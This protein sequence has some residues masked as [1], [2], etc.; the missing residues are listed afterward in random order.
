MEFFMAMKPNKIKSFMSCILVGVTLFMVF[1]LIISI[2]IPYTFSFFFSEYSILLFFFCWI[3]FS[4]SFYFQGWKGWLFGLGITLILFA[5]PLS[6]KW[7]SGIS[8]NQIIAGL[9]PYKD[10][11]YYYNGALNIL[12]GNMI[13]SNNLPSSWRPLFP[14][15]FSTLLFLTGR[16]LKWSIALLTYFAGV[17]CYLA[18]RQMRTISG[19]WAA[20]LFMVFLFFYSSPYIGFLGT[21]LSG[22]LVSCLAFSLLSYAAQKFEIK[23]LL[24]GMIILMLAISTR[25]GAFVIFPMLVLWSGWF[26][27]KERRFS[28][29]VAGLSFLVAL[30]SFLLFN[31]L[32]QKSIVEPGEAPLSNFAYV[33]YGQALGGTGWQRGVQDFGYNSQLVFSTALELIQKHPLSFL[34][35]TLKSYRDVLLPGSGILIP[36]R[37]SGQFRIDY[38]LWGLGYLLLLWAGFKLMKNWRLPVQSF[39]LAAFLG[40]ILSVT[41]LPPVDGGSRFYT[42]AAP[43]IVALPAYGL[44]DLLSRWRKK[45][46]DNDPNVIMVVKST[47]ILFLLI[48]LITPF[49][50]ML[51][52]S[53][54]VIAVPVC[55]ADQVAFTVRMD[56]GSFVDIFPAG[57]SSCGIVPDVCLGDFEANGIE[58]NVD[59]FYQVLLSEASSSNVATRVL[60]STDQAGMQRHYFVGD[61]QLLSGE[62]SN[63]M[64]SGCATALRTQYQSI[65]LIQSVVQATP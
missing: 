63:H 43:F 16:N 36:L 15:Q 8:N 47:S 58:K 33:L 39:F 64:L 24:L 41:F 29:K 11:N 28:F 65:Y 12:S 51:F 9:L 22:I 26:F 45:T 46:A 5:L 37:I 31:T 53:E 7:T 30:L 2:K 42:S 62:S 40:V 57:D 38:V 18:G 50:L 32:F 55:P 34:I 1:A 52:I 4:L 49:L 44:G 27:K 59:D 23:A 48:T 20:G 10:S 60:T 19:N 17:A 54:P 21:E 35:A 14:A 6:F 56:P 61:A 25:A 13:S 3:L